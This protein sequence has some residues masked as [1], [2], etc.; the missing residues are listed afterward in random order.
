MSF[1]LSKSGGSARHGPEWFC[2]TLIRA[3]SGAQTQVPQGLLDFAGL[4]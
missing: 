2:T 1:K 3:M 4:V